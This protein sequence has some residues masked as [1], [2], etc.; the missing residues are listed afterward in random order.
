M[1]SLAKAAADPSGH[2]ARPDVTRLMLNRT[3]GDRVIN[4]TMPG[5]V[6]DEA[7]SDTVE[8]AAFAAEREA[9][10]TATKTRSKP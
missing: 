2:Y 7:G 5:M 4:F 9:S 3:P 8:R 10:K 1:I 6:V